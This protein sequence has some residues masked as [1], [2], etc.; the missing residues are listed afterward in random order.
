MSDV[1]ARTGDKPAVIEPPSVSQNE[2]RDWI[3]E[4]STGGGERDAAL[5][6]LHALLVRGARHQVARM[7]GQLPGVGTVVC[8]EIAQSAADEALAVLLTSSPCVRAGV[9][10]WWPRGCSASS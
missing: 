8:E 1:A 5:S 6:D 9:L 2:L 4:L 7:R 10:P 3:G